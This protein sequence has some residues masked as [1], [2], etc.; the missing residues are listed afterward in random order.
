MSMLSPTSQGTIEIA[1]ASPA[2]TDT[3]ECLSTGVAGPL[4]G[5]PARDSASSLSA[6]PFEVPKSSRYS[7]LQKSREAIRMGAGIGKLISF[8][9]SIWAQEAPAL[10]AVDRPQVAGFKGRAVGHFRYSK[11]RI[12]R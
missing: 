11:E 8:S 6:E 2:T 4:Q 1:S 5:K 9:G 3:I 12:T 7:E 10:T